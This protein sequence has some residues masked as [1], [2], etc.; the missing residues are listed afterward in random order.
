MNSG[1]ISG[2]SVLLRRNHS[3]S[4]FKGLAGL[5][6]LTAINPLQRMSLTFSCRK[7]ILLDTFGN[8]S[9]STEIM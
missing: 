6:L 4:H 3:A 2:L 7:S 5:V 8:G 9:V 1:K